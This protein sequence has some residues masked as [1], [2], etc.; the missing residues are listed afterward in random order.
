MYR[1]EALSPSLVRHA[2]RRPSRLNCNQVRGYWLVDALFD[3][4]HYAR[5]ATKP[6][7]GGHT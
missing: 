7:L 6:G 5:S 3:C 1:S 2:M 4:K